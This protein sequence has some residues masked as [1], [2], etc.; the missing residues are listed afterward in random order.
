MFDAIADAMLLT[1]DSGH[2]VLVN[3]AAQQ[4][5]GYSADELSGIAIGMLIVPRY[6]KQYRYHQNAATTLCPDHI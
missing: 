1:E 3:P 2:I 4:L 6:R 5:F